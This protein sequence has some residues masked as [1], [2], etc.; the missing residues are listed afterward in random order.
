MYK[1]RQPT[2][3]EETH[4]AGHTGETR[5]AA[6]GACNAREKAAERAAQAPR[7]R[8]RRTAGGSGGRG[9][10]SANQAPTVACRPWPAGR[11]DEDKPAGR[12]DREVCWARP[13]RGAAFNGLAAA[14]QLARIGR[15]ATPLPAAACRGGRH[16][17]VRERRAEVTSRSG[18]TLVRART[19]TQSSNLH[20]PLLLRCPSFSRHALLL[21]PPAALPTPSLT[22][23]GPSWLLPANRCL[24]RCGLLCCSCAST[25][26][27]RAVFR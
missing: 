19:P 3:R 1:Q 9:R 13:R 27:S 22:P 20:C 14:S 16:G 7:R 17:H 24:W 4:G 25:H 5:P 6:Q 18:G 8:R 2:V 15:T 12:R 26:T 10:R 11:Q 23:S 21:P